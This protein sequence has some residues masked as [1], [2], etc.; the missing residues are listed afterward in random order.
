M[1]MR[2]YVCVYNQI[3]LELM[4]PLG[5]GVTHYAN[6]FQPSKC[7]WSEMG[8]A[9]DLYIFGICKAKAPSQSNQL[10]LLN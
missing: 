6:S 2:P 3:S 10:G 4:V 1:C 8:E 5:N 9:G 7:A